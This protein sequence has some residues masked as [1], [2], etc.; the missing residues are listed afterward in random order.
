MIG[1]VTVEMCDL[2]CTL[3]FFIIVVIELTWKREVR[4]ILWNSIAM[5]KVKKGGYDLTGIKLSYLQ[6]EKFYI[7]G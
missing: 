7:M 6:M 5:D 3:I 4:Q 1:Q 2:T